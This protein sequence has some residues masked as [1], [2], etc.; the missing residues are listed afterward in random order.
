MSFGRLARF[1]RDGLGCRDALYFDG[2]VSSLRAPAL[3]RRDGGYLLGPMV[4]ILSRP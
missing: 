1:L 3:G 4:A 2:A